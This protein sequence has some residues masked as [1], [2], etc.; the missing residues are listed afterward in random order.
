MIGCVLGD[1]RHVRA[2]ASRTN[3]ERQ[4]VGKKSI[5]IDKGI[6]DYKNNYYI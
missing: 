1:A 3:T 5:K 2:C 4:A 6:D